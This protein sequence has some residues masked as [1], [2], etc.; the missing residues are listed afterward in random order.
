VLWLSY[1]GL[2]LPVDVELPLEALQCEAQ[3]SPPPLGRRLDDLLAPLTEL[4]QTLAFT[5]AHFSLEAEVGNSH[6]KRFALC[7]VRSK[8]TVSVKYSC[9]ESL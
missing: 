7:E 1:L 4:P 2:I 9:W 3:T 8:V 5:E 6:F